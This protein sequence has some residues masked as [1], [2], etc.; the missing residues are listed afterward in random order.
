[1]D[2]MVRSPARAMETL[3]KLT[4]LNTVVAT[5]RRRLRLFLAVA[6]VVLLAVIAYTLQSTPRYTATA[7][8]LLDPRTQQVTDIEGVLS[9][10]P[11]DSG[12][13]DTEV[14]IL[15]SRALAERVVTALK[16]DRDPDYNPD[17]E[18]PGPLGS[19]LGAARS[20]EGA[21][22]SRVEQQKR[23]EAV[24]DRVLNDLS[25]ERAGTTFMIR[26]SYTSDDPEKAQTIANAFADRYLLEQLEAK[27]EATRSANEWLNIRLGELRVQV[28]SAEAAVE[29][30]KAAY[31]LMSAQ[32]SSLTEAEISNLNQQLA[33]VRVEQAEAEARLN[34]ARAQL[35]RGSTGE[36]VGEALGS[37]VIQELRKQRAEVSRKVAEL[38][39]RYSSRHPEIQKT[40][41]E[42]ADIDNQ[43]RG[44]IQ[45]IVSNLEAQ[46][47]VQRQR[48]ASLSGSVARSRGT[49][50][51]NN[52]AMVRLRELERNA[53]S[54]RTLYESFLNRFK[55]TSTQEGIEQSDARVVSRAKIPT[56]PSSPNVPLN[57][58]VGLLLAL[59]AGAGAVV[60]REALDTGLGTAEEIEDLLGLPYLA[61]VPTLASTLKKG[62]EGAD[63]EPI[64]YVVARPLSSFSE[65]FR[66]L[67][68]SLSFARV[69][70]PVKVIAITSSLPDEG[71]TTTSI[72]LARTVALS[73]AR[74]V[75]V[76]CDLRRRALNDAIGEEVS[77][78]LIEVLS[79]ACTL[80]EALLID[81]ETGASFLPLAKS[82]YTPKDVFGTSAMDRL[83]EDLRER[84][85]IVI[86]DT[87]PVLP[88]AD[89]RVL[90]PKADAVA[91]LVRWRHTPRKAIEGSLRML[92]S[93]NAFIAGAVLTQ[94]DL[95][96][97]ARYG[98]G[99]P[100]YYYRSYS[101]Y[102]AQ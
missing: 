101:K 89:T 76:D 61:G 8:V 9:G 48:T 52:Q 24:V 85:D 7:N 32:G 33:T 64:D 79:G 86:L 67:K 4:D 87:A 65:A 91:L 25:V 31:G 40:Q 30:Y 95:K 53:E 41:R 74:V 97:Q 58:A 90:A 82:A 18:E 81:D 36:D 57:L 39:T 34:T 92:Q 5:F 37:Q 80:E 69:G 43:I 68:T 21:K 35:A 70:E 72:C 54:V 1:M 26:V 60:L 55:E 10:L 14:E 94:I 51:G 56:G 96:E 6:V 71:K 98:Y 20:S 102:Y 2:A 12:T 49:L 27:F 45:R 99:D 83:L 88:V 84:F 78:G 46:A 75:V 73:G 63:A 19:L 3:G 38:E 29:Q 47:Q 11:A 22:L 44:E 17:L 42:L 23:H 62:D 100:G 66:N 16:L 13:V 28:Q 77:K 93:G 15:K 59:G 50:A